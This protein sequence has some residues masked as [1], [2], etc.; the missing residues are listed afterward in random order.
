V[1]IEYAIDRFSMETKRLLDVL[2]KA[3][4]TLFAL[5]PRTCTGPLRALLTC[6][7]TSVSAG[8]AAQHLEGKQWVCGD[9]YSIADMATWPWIMCIGCA[10]PLRRRRFHCRLRAS[11]GSPRLSVLDVWLVEG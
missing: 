7:L 10:R 8:A 1:H 9:E 3:R 4:L 5:R 6:A 2:D 11:L